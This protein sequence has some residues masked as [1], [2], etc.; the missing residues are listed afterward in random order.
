MHYNGDS[1]TTWPGS[2]SPDALLGA[3]R[4]LHLAQTRRSEAEQEMAEA[5]Y[6][7]DNVVFLGPDFQRDRSVTMQQVCSIKPAAS[8]A[9]P[10]RRS[11]AGN[12]QAPVREQ[13]SKIERRAQLS[14]EKLIS[15]SS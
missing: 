8:H 12:K 1:K 9:R 13:R 15:I 14:A 6:L 2:R 7:Q 3:L 10:A 5:S 11:R 4:K